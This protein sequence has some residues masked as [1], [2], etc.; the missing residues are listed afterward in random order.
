MTE[1]FLE[2]E[3]PRLLPQRRVRV[4]E[5]GC[6]SGSLVRRLAA[7][8]YSGEYLGVDIDDRF[9]LGRGRD[10]PFATEFVCG[11][12]HDVTPDHPVDLLVSVSA[13]EHIA[14]DRQLIARFPQ[15]IRPG[16]LWKLMPSRRPPACWRTSGTVTGSIRQPALP[17]VWVRRELRS[18][19]SNWT[20]MV[21]V[22]TITVPE[23]L[24]NYSFRKS[25][26]AF[27]R[28]SIRIGLALDRLLPVAAT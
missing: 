15:L 26:P 22:L 7:I 13:I 27:Y 23:L 17:S 20:L 2:R 11:D 21:H 8:G 4:F 14:N 16:G 1:L 12:A 28:A 9:R 19:A 6:G 3:L 10:G 5:I 24:L 18:S 25:V